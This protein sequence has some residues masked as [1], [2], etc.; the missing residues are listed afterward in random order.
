MADGAQSMG[1]YKGEAGEVRLH[2][3]LCRAA[4]NQL[5]IT[6]CVLR[7]RIQSKSDFPFTAR[8]SVKGTA[9]R[10]GARHGG[11]V[12]LVVTVFEELSSA[13]RS[14]LVCKERRSGVPSGRMGTHVQSATSQLLPKGPHTGF[15][16]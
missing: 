11:R 10:N 12:T 13:K 14:G 1:A 5:P 16:I 9:G 15:G 6:R 8:A 7:I 3:L 2:Q 4:P